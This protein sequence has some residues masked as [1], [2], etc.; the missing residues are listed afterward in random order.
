MQN[1]KLY[2]V[3]IIGK[4]KSSTSY[5][6]LPLFCCVFFHCVAAWPDLSYMSFMAHTILCQPHTVSWICTGTSCDTK[7]TYSG[8]LIELVHT[9]ECFLILLGVSN[10]ASRIES[11][12]QGFWMFVKFNI[13]LLPKT[14]NFIKKCVAIRSII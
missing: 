4:E 8:N 10:A 13:F 11:Q 6:F 12:R 7:C 14:Y 3:Y 2:S 9:L 1:H 5:F